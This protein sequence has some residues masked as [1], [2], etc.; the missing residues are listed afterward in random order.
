MLWV[1]LIRGNSRNTRCQDRESKKNLKKSYKF[2]LIF[3]HIFVECLTTINFRDV[4]LDE[5]RFRVNLN[6]LSKLNCERFLHFNNKVCD[7]C[8]GL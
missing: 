5:P 1:D 8:A 6:N 3:E 2:Q 7:G 4:L